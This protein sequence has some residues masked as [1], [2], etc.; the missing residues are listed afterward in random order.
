MLLLVQDLHS[1]IVV[2]Y[3]ILQV[4][5]LVSFGHFIVLMSCVCKQKEILCINSKEEQIVKQR[6]HEAVD[7]ESKEKRHCPETGVEMG[8][9]F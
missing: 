9:R 7:F 4:Y 6:K 5:F 1:G 2:F 8:F 3:L